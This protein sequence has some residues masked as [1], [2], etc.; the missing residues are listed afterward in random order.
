MFF[1]TGFALLVVWGAETFDGM[2]ASRMARAKFAANQASQA[3]SS[4]PAAQDGVPTSEVD[5][6]SWSVKRLQAY[7]DSILNKADT[8]LAVLLIPKVQLEVPLFNGTDDRTLNRG[9]RRILGTA[10]VGTGNLGIAGHRDGF[11]RALKDVAKGGVIELARPSQ[12][13]FYVIDAIQIVHSED[14]SVLVSTPTPTLTLVTCFPFYFVGG[15]ALRYVVRASLKR[16]SQL[17]ESC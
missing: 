5:F 13:D 6:A 12:T 17:G 7:R 11:F 2:V 10:Q 4:I 3:V 15:A 1:A 8:P 14:V 9:V 16:S